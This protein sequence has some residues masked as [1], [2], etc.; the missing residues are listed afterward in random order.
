MKLLIFTLLFISQSHASLFRVDRADN[1]LETKVIYG[2]DDRREIYEAPGQWQE[3]AQSTVTIIRSDQI[4]EG[5]KSDHFKLIG[6]TFGEKENLCQDEPYRD[7]KMVAHCSAFLIAPDVVATAGHCIRDDLHCKT[8]AY[9]FDVK[10][11]KAQVEDYEI[12]KKNFYS[13]KKLI[14]RVENSVLKLD[15][16]L[17]RLNKEVTDR[18]ALSIRK[19]GRPSLGDEMAV[20]GHPY[21][22]FKKFADNGFILKNHHPSF[23]SVDLDTYSYNSG[24]PIFNVETKK[25]E[26]ILVRGQEDFIFDEEENCNRSRICAP[27]KCNGEEVTRMSEVKF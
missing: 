16:A 26:G 23:F 27:G 19:A 10:M 21:G 22:I 20:I 18:E 13:C 25:V 5:D 9:V 12:P 24:S 14:K 1:E 3:L 6:P 17:I 11:N 2:A 4:V 7:Q 15:Y 8:L